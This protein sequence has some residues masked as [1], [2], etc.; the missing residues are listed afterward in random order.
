MDIGDWL[1]D[2]DLAKY[3]KALRENAIDLVVLPDLTDGDLAQIGEALGDLFGGSKPC[4]RLSRRLG[5]SRVMTC[6]PRRAHKDFAQPRRRRRGRAGGRIDPVDG[7]HL[8]ARACF[9]AHPARD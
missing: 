2:R 6:E 8:V 1:R 4:Q 7:V 9:A 3:E 5:R